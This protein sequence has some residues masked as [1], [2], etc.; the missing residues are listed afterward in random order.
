MD[1]F[2]AFFVSW[3][4]LA[5]AAGVLIGKSIAMADRRETEPATFPV[6]EP[7]RRWTA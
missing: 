7:E 2:L 4:F 3:T 6:D 5:L 1:L